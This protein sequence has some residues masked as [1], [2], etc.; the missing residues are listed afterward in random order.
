MSHCGTRTKGHTLSNGAANARKHTAAPAAGGGRRRL[1][2]TSR[3]RSRGSTV[4]G[5]RTRDGTRRRGTAGTSTCAT[6]TL[7]REKAE[8]R[9]EGGVSVKDSIPMGI[10][11]SFFRE[12]H[13]VHNTAIARH[14]TTRHEPV[15][16]PLPCSV[17][18]SFTSLA[19]KRES[20]FW[21]RPRVGFCSTTQHDWELACLLTNPWFW[22]L[23]DSILRL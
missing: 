14:D 1:R 8:K 19:A 23:F 16:V 10:D 9:K 6:R 11:A 21:I 20:D 12:S 5:S 4:S 2:R 18:A 17:V 22:L 15:T 13:L 7:C 3:R